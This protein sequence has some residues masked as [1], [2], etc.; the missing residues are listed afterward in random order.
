MENISPDTNER[1][2]TGKILRTLSFNTEVRVVLIPSIQDYKEAE[3]HHHLWYKKTD[4]IGFK[5]SCRGEIQAH[6]NA[7]TTSITT[8][9]VLKELYQP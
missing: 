6:K 4:F 9:E 3:L 1:T 5:N 7:G 2:S 8:R